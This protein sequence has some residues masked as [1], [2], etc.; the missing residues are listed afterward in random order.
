VLMKVI[1]IIEI[2]KL[3]MIA[4]KIVMMLLILK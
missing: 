1:S 4:I 2:I 3:M